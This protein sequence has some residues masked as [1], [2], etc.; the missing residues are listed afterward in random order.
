MRLLNVGGGSKSIPIPSWY[1]G[2]E[3]V[4]LDIVAGVDVD[5][6]ADARALDIDGGFD[7]I[8][9]S[10]NLEHFHEAEI[11][12]VLAGFRRALRVGGRLEV[13]V[14]DG[15]Q[16]E[17]AIADVGLHGE[18]YHTAIGPITPYDMIHG[19][20]ASIEAGQPHMAH[21]MVFT[22]ATLRA[23]LAD[24][25]FRVVCCEPGAFELVALARKEV[26]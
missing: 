15:D 2:F 11:P 1:E 19:H 8:Y 7:A 3:H 24:A 18:A 20:Q 21:H 9:C 23:C 25:E 13:R 22:P 12:N 4:L 6:V 10:H 17:A 5:I 14:P 16:I 26:P